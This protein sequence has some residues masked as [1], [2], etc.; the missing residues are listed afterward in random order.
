MNDVAHILRLGAALRQLDDAALGS[1]RHAV[2]SQRSLSDPLHS[3]LRDVHRLTGPHAEMELR[4][5]SYISGHAPMF[6]DE[7][8]DEYRDYLVD[9]AGVAAQDAREKAQQILEDSARSGLSVNDAAEEL[10]KFFS[11]FTQGRLRTIIRTESGRV[12][13]K[14]RD[15]VLQRALENGTGP[16]YLL[17]SAI[18]DDRTTNTC[19]FGDGYYSPVESNGPWNQSILPAHWNC[20]SIRRFLYEGDP[21]LDTG[22]LWTDAAWSAYRAVQ[23]REFPG[24]N[25]LS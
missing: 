10:G 25:P 9:L 3:Y 23:E 22:R 21:E 24:W 5:R 6:D 14:T 1:M 2:V 18:L 20:R 17:Y 19:S 8:A 4:Q 7:L 11:G 15:D 13:N 12:M 16:D